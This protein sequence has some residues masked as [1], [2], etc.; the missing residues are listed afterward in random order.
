M[1]TFLPSGK[2]TQSDDNKTLT[3]TENTNYGAND[4]GIVTGD[5]SARELKLY[6]ANN[7]L[8]ATLTLIFADGV[9]K[10]TYVIAADIY[11]SGV[12]K[13][14]LTAGPIYSG[15][16]NYTS[17]G[18]YNSAFLAALKLEKDCGCKNNNRCSDINFSQSL[19]SEAILLAARGFG[20]QSQQAIT[21]AL[22][23]VTPPSN[24]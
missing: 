18:F 15:T 11:V 3:Y 19:K 6:D 21:D 14:T 4:Q 23:L 9:W 1:S 24:C 16:N 17:V 8:L 5:V 13:V 2:F 12:L 7:V 10:A 20:L 22:V